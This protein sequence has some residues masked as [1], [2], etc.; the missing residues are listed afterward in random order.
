[1]AAESVCTST[2]GETAVKFLEQLN[3]IPEK[4]RTDKVIAFTGRFLRDFCKT[5]FIKLLC[6][7]PCIHTGSVLVERGEL[8]N[9]S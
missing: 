8:E 3:V 9:T 1:M 5:H 4:I 6:G 2:D 7:T